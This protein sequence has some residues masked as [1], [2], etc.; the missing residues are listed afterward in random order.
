MD[1]SNLIQSAS[2]QNLHILHIIARQNG[3]I[4]AEHHFEED[5][6]TLLWS[7]SKTFTSMAVGIA[8]HEG[9]FQICERIADYFP[10][11]KREKFNQLTIRDLLCMGTGQVEC[12]V[13]KAVASGR[14]LDDIEALF[15]EEPVIYEP[16]KHFMYNNA[17]TYMLSKL[18]SITTG[19]CLL[20]YL[21]PRI[22]EPL[23]ISNVS[24]EEDVNGVN[25]GCSGLY[26]K[27]HDLSKFGQLLLNEGAW[28][29]KSLIPGQYI[30]EATQKQIDS[31]GF[32]KPFAT[33]DHK[34]GYGYQLWMNSY[35]GSYRLDGLYGNYMVIIPEKNAVITYVSNEPQKMTSILELTWK[36]VVDQL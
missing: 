35:P 2:E 24:W 7:V 34:S 6:P 17:A 29:G 9:F 16:G 18:I 27:A 10:A 26:I 4:N 28:N 32:D 36:F 22:F 15:F 20:D 5:T 21:R 11:A 12:P 19:C 3:E 30:Q 13:D 23:G 33:L 1:F 14:D 25:Y 31:S 8:A